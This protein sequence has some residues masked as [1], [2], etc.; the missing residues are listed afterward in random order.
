MHTS[1]PYAIETSVDKD[2]Q[3]SRGIATALVRSRMHQAEKLGLDIFA[4][5]M[6]PGVKVY[7]GLGFQM[8]REV[9]Q[10]DSK[11]RGPGLFG[12]SFPVYKHVDA[13]VG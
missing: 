10:D 6:K 5:A 4:H 11:Y 3:C 7:Q 1:S 2:E 13:T 9:I 8:E 12:D